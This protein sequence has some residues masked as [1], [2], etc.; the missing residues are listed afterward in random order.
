MCPKHPDANV[1]LSSV[2]EQWLFDVLLY[3]KRV[4]LDLVWLDHHFCEGFI[5]LWRLLVSLKTRWVFGIRLSCRLFL[6]TSNFLTDAVLPYKLVK[7]VKVI[8]HMDATTSIQVRGLQDPQI[9]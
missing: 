3:D 8:K 2:D 6:V 9:V 1:E 5:L 7:L 4:K